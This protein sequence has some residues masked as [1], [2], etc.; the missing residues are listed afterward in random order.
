MLNNESGSTPYYL[1]HEGGSVYYHNKTI[2]TT[3]DD[4]LV[5]N[6]VK[7]LQGVGV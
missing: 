3:I 4:L 5:A 7:Q 6:H 1:D 2:R